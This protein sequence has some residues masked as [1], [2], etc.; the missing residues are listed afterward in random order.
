MQSA[1]DK[2]A[3]G[4]SQLAHGF[5]HGAQLVNPTIKIVSKA[6]QDFE[7]TPTAEAVG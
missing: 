5:S 1:M 2:L 4:L 6:L 7:R 3:H